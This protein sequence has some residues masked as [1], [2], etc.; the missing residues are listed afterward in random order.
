MEAPQAR[1]VALKRG[2][3][4]GT[5][6]L[7]ARLPGRQSVSSPT[8]LP[9]ATASSGEVPKVA[10]R[11][12]KTIGTGGSFF[13]SSSYTA[14]QSQAHMLAISRLEDKVEEL[15]EPLAGLEW[16]LLT[17]MTALE[18]RMD[19]RFADAGR[20]VRQLHRNSSQGST[21]FERGTVDRN[22]GSGGRGSSRGQTP[23][24]LPREAASEG[25]GLDGH[26]DDQQRADEAREVK[27]MNS[28]IGGDE[29]IQKLLGELREKL[30]R[31]AHRDHTSHGAT[32]SR[33]STCCRSATV[34]SSPGGTHFSRRSRHA[35]LKRIGGSTRTFSGASGDHAKVTFRSLCLRT[36]SALFGRVMHP[37]APRM[38]VREL[39]RARAHPGTVG[40][41][42]AYPSAA[43]VRSQVG[44]Y[45]GKRYMGS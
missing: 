4:A 40:E 15:L 38:I 13:G 42:V 44:R 28:L 34:D 32:G 1:P 30:E 12:M 18:A 2:L 25:T 39:A 37:G 6:Q 5:G 7:F 27:L 19:K 14:A 35:A 31:R 43:A 10:L 29:S 45:A 8:S 41:R 21:L 33:V 3:T 16:R 11:R 20:E 22:G 23:S 26:A 24:P 36:V 17:R 9:S